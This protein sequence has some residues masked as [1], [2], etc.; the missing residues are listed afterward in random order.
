MGANPALLLLPDFK[1]WLN[2][3]GL[4]RPINTFF[5]SLKQL[6]T[7]TEEKNQAILNEN[8]PKLVEIL[9]NAGVQKD[10]E[11]ALKYV[12]SYVAQTPIKAPPANGTVYVEDVS[13]DLMNA[14]N[15]WLGQNLTIQQIKRITANGHEQWIE[16]SSSMGSV[17]ESWVE[18]NLLTTANN[19]ANAGKLT[20]FFNQDGIISDTK[21]D[22]NYKA[23]T[24]DCHYVINKQIIA[25]EAKHIK[26]RFDKHQLIQIERNAA[27]VAKGKIA[28]FE[29]IFSTK[30]AAEKNKADIQS[31][32]RR[33]NVINKLKISFIEDPTGKV[34]D[35]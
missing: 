9:K 16:Q 32:F 27:L 25:V 30:A 29:Y 14:I 13:S 19:K 5:N 7:T 1:K 31:E 34:I 12:K 26:G 3:C 35:I 11:P 22:A 8:E 15:K 10:L 33:M 24:I 20:F 6:P 2:D 23:H 18:T 28:Q 4:K 21:L 17:F